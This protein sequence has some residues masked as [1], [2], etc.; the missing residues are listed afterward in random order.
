[1]DTTLSGEQLTDPGAVI[2]A[3]V[4]Q[5][6]GGGATDIAVTTHPLWIVGHGPSGCRFQVLWAQGQETYYVS[7][8]TAADAVAEALGAF[9]DWEAA[10][11]CALQ[12]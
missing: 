3:I 4:H 1:M 9:P 6:R 8:W 10:I 11:A 2:E 12:A 5:L 7:R